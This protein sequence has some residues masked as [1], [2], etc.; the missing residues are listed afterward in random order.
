MTGTCT[1]CGAAVEADASFCKKC[2]VDLTQAFTPPPADPE[3]T[4]AAP[5]APPASPSSVQGATDPQAETIAM[6]RGSETVQMPQ[7]AETVVAPQGALPTDATVVAGTPPPGATVPAGATAVPAGQPPRVQATMRQQLRDATLGEYEILSELGRGGMATVF[8][9]HDISLDRKVAIKVMAPHLLEG[10]GMVERFK[11]EA[12]TAAQLSHPHIIPIYAVKWTDTTIYFVM[13]FIEGRPLDDIIKKMAPLPVPMVKDILIKVGGALGYGHRREVVH[14]DI[15]PANIMIDEEGTPIVTDFGIAKVANEGGGLTMTGTTIGTPSYMSPEQCEAKEVSGA[16]DQYSLGVLAWEMLTGKLPFEGQSAVSTMYMHCH[17][18]LPPLLDF[19]PDCPAEVMETV[20]RMLAKD[21]KDRWPS[22]EAAI[23][24]LGT[25]STMSYMDP[26]HSELVELVKQGDHRELLARIQTPR[27]PIPV[28]RTGQ[29]TAAGAAEPKSKKGLVIGGI[30]TAAVAA[31]LAVFQPWTALST[32]DPGAAPPAV[33]APAQNPAAG[34]P[35]TTTPDPGVVAGGAGVDDGADP[36]DGGSDATEAPVESDPVVEEPTTPVVEDRPAQPAAAT[37][38]SVRIENAPGSMT[39]GA[40]ANLAGIVMG[41]DG[42]P[43]N[44][45]PTWQSSDANV[46]SVDGTGRLIAREPGTAVITA[47][48]GN[49]STETTV[50]VSAVPVSSVQLSTSTL[51]LIAG[52]AGDRVTATVLGSNGALDRPVSWESSDRG[53]ATVDGSGNVQ[54]VAPGRAQL[55]AE[56]GGRTAIVS[57]TVLEAPRA[58]A[59]RIIAEYAAAIESRDIGRV[60]AVHSGLT[61]EQD[62]AF[63]NAFP[64]MNDLQADLSIQSFSVQGTQ[65]TAQ[66]VG[67]YVFNAGGRQEAPQNFTALFELRGD[68]WRLISTR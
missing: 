50:T 54:G 12:R 34:E 37:V 38:A 27:S 36:A 51:R 20:E 58:A 56:S 62:E 43:M 26:V 46:V 15:K 1:R 4:Q 68:S 17:E 18:P 59:D 21:P 53:V 60:R 66:V 47:R 32:G 16:S 30:A 40:S 41:S 64:A 63:S 44:R 61:R 7:G 8:L 28:G 29:A 33:E 45:T 55:T 10:D 52:E 35:A 14:R 67:S 11:L 13:K 2:G 31:A 57:V 49:R 48:S 19:R 6:P 39:V 24:K 25:E 5:P 42:N 22:L 23:Q 65:A 3:A 9:A